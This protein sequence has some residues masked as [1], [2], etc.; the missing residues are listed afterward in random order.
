MRTDILASC[1][2][3]EYGNYP[4][5]RLLITGAVH[6]NERCGTEAITRV[7]AELDS[8]TLSLRSGPVSYTHLTLPTSDLV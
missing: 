3:H 8:G 5:P 4:G 7:M 2:S 6:G 1:V